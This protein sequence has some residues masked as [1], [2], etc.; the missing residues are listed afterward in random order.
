MTL[1]TVDAPAF[2][3]APPA[4]VRRA[5]PVWVG[6]WLWA[7][8]GLVILM[9]VVGG[10]TRLTGSG[11]SITQWRPVAGALPPLSHADW[12]AEFSRYQESSQAQLLNAGMSLSQFKHIFW[13]EWA[14]RQLGRFIGLFFAGGFVFGLATRQF[15]W[16]LGSALA[17]MGVLLGFQGVIGWIMVASGLKAGMTA[18]EP[19]D[20]AAHLLFASLFLVTLVALVT[21]LGKNGA[22]PAKAASPR[23]AALM[24]MLILPLVLTQLALGALVAGS[25][26]GLLYNTWPDMDGR[27]VPPLGELFSVSPWWVNP[28]EN[29]TLIQLDH[30]LLAYGLLALVLANAF[31]WWRGEGGAPRRLALLLAGIVL[32]QVALGIA[33]LVHAVP[34]G[35]A[36][37]HQLLAMFA[38]VAATRLAVLSRSAK[39][40]SLAVARPLAA[41]VATR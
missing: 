40:V 8:A 12:L 19:L 18:V 24:S 25:H 37:A 30:R 3:V 10:A 39:S 33:T 26:A 14:H 7:T 11:L 28:F 4:G 23:H 29:A 32:A 38:L 5:L 2:G 9:V 31:I 35:L 16:R 22:F 34:L 20:L 15:S 6:A 1:S 21:A 17:G 13:W 36:L 41:P 27:F